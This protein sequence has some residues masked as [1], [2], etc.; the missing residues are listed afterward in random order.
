LA[1]NEP[2]NQLT[3]KAESDRSR[4]SAL[5]PWISRG[6]RRFGHR[7]A[8]FSSEPVALAPREKVAKRD[9]GV[10]GRQVKLTPIGVCQGILDAWL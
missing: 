9:R 4:L 1:R 10:N 5:K 2:V 3:Q 6:L 7:G 8:R